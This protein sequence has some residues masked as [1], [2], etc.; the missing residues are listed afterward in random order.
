MTC[1]ILPPICH[2]DIHVGCWGWTWKCSRAWVAPTSETA[3]PDVVW[4]AQA[5]EEGVLLF[6]EALKDAQ[7]LQRM[8]R[9]TSKAAGKRGSV[10]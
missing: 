10:H 6:L 3:A 2:S 4:S 1:G 5:G 7:I 9:K 8:V